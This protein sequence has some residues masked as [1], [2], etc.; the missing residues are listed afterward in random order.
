[1]KKVFVIWSDQIEGLFHTTPIEMG[2]NSDVSKMSGD[3]LLASAVNRQYGN[4]YE[5]EGIELVAI[6]DPNGSDLKFL[7][8]EPTIE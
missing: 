6:I 4:D 8:G 5:M 3:D 7:Y 2:P 1:M